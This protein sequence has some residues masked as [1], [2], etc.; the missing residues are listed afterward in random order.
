[1]AGEFEL[2]ADVYDANWAAQG[3]GPLLLRGASVSRLMDGG[4]QIT[5]QAVM[6]ERALDLLIPERRVRLYAVQ[7]SGDV[8]ELGRGILNGV[9]K[10]KSDAGDLMTAQGDDLL[11]VL[12]RKIIYKSFTSP[13]TIDA[14]ASDLASEAGWTAEVEAGL[15]VY[16]QGR[17]YGANVLKALLDA[18]EE[19]GLHLRFKYDLP[20]ISTPVVEIGALGASSGV[21]LTNLDV[22][23]TEYDEP[24]VG[25][26]TDLRLDE[27]SQQMANCII[28][29]GGGEGEAAIT[30]AKS[31]RTSPYAIQT[32]AFVNGPTVY[33]ICD[34]DSVA[35]YGEIWRSLTFKNIIPPAN[36]EA[37]KVAAANAL[38]DSG[39][40][41]LQR[42]ANPQAAYSC[43]VVGLETRVLPGDLVHV[44][45]RG[46]VLKD[47]GTYDVR[48]DVD[49]DFYVLAV[50]ERA[51][52]MGIALDLQI[53]NIDQR[54]RNEDTVIVEAIENIQLRSRKPQIFPYVFNDSWTDTVQYGIT[55]VPNTTASIKKAKFSVPISDIVTDV[56]SVKLRVKTFPLKAGLLFRSRTISALSTFMTQYD[57]LFT[58]VENAYYPED[59]T[60]EINGVDRTSAL[61]GPWGA[62][63]S[64]VDVELDVTEYIVDD[65]GGLYQDHEIVFY[66]GAAS[67]AFTISLINAGSVESIW[68]PA[69]TSTYSAGIVQLAVQV[70]GTAQAI[71]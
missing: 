1:M 32:K 52:E 62:Y 45:Y 42:N 60:I 58:S 44:A 28:I 71:L 21:Q 23:P 47:D 11:E 7:P 66:C 63:T 68:T 27:T 48:G 20:T 29:Q 36:T 15:D 41:W 39:A 10:T 61:G 19:N 56:A 43:S 5:I 13:V 55:A 35:T 24:L 12:K 59:L 70:L 9:S 8:Y 64:A 14:F 46:D 2:W 31:T 17:I 65:S 16:I 67:S 53:S 34:S 26:I 6:D 18:C 38:Y 54:V 50:T 40:E 69:A 57:P 37:A 25:V 49:G 30:L 4:G 33:Y 3:D 51:S 22:A